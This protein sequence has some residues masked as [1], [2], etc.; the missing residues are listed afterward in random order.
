MN[1]IRQFFSVYYG[2]LRWWDILGLL[3]LGVVV[4]AALIFGHF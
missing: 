3:V 4:M 2:D 1:R